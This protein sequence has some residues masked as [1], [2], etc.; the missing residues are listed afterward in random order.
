MYICER[1]AVR[2][3]TIN[4]GRLRRSKRSFHSSHRR[5]VATTNKPYPS[6]LV[7]NAQSPEELAKWH[8][9]ARAAGARN[10]SSFVRGLFQG[11]RGLGKSA[12]LKLAT[13]IQS[14][15]FSARTLSGIGNNLNQLTRSVHSHHPQAWPEMPRLLESVKR[16]LEQNRALLQ[17]ILDTLD[18]IRR[19]DL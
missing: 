9:I 13:L 4:A 17:E 16:E 10:T 8:A 14:H 3:R 2:K 18:A 1:Q 12:V 19:G 11:R 15:Q 5:L 7:V 6:R